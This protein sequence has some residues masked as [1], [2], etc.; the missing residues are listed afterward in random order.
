MKITRISED[1]KTIGMRVRLPVKLLP[2]MPLWLFD[3]ML[4]TGFTVLAVLGWLNVRMIIYLIS[5]A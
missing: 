2:D 3:T 4:F 5:R 1:G